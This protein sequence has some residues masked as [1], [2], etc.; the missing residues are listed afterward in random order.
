MKNKNERGRQAESVGVCE[1]IRLLFKVNLN[2][3]VKQ[4]AALGRKAYLLGI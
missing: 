1:V 3:M 4:V 2:T